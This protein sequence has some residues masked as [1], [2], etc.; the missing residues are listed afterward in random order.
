VTVSKRTI[1]RNDILPPARYAAERGALRPALLELKRLRRVA[2]G[3]AA[4]AHFECFDTVRAQIHEMLRIEGGGEAQ[5][6][7]ELRAYA[8]LVP[9]G[10]ELVLT[11]MFEIDDPARRAALLGRLGGVEHTVSLQFRGETITAVP[12]RDV[13][14]TS[15]GGKASS[16]HFLHLPFTAGQAALFRTPGLAAVFGI[17][18]PEYGHLAI[19]PEATRQ[20]LAEDLD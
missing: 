11:L 2:V 17:G 3:P 6:E 10:R 4:T 15:E 12:E 5:L 9:N 14:R 1:D 20:A 19:L 13:E 8:P 18:H 7:D 16:V